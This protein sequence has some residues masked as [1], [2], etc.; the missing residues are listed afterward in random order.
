M[1]V[2]RLLT[3]RADYLLGCKANSNVIK[4][5]GVMMVIRVVNSEGDYHLG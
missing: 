1:K 4:F 2:I 5:V 3:A